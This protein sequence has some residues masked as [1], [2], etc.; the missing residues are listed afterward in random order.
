MRIGDAVSA[1]HL[2]EN[3]LFRNKRLSVKLRIR[4]YSCLVTSRLLSAA[5]TIPMTKAEEKRMEATQTSHLRRIPRV[6]YSAYVPN[7]AVRRSSKI[8]AVDSRLMEARLRIWSRASRDCPH[9]FFR[10]TTFCGAAD[11]RPSFEKKKQIQY[12]K[13]IK[14]AVHKFGS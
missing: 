13:L 2:L 8:P 6:P 7:E 1:W 11:E 12:V 9:S 14:D 4:L 3:K 5:E 10:A